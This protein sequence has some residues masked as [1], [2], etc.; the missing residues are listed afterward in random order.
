MTAAAFHA[1]AE[2]RLAEGDPAGARVLLED[3]LRL[4]PRCLPAALALAALRLPEDPAAA[5]AMAEA[6]RRDHPQD[7]RVLDLLGQ[8]VSALGRTAHAVAAFAAACAAAPRDAGRA[9]NLAVAELRAGDA[10]ASLRTAQR[11]AALDPRLPEA[12]AAIGHALAAL[13]RHEEALEAFHASLAL[14]PAQA[15][16]LLGVARS[17]RALGEAE[18][19]AIALLRAHEVAPEAIEPAVELPGALAEAA[20]AEAARDAAALLL[21]HWPA[22]LAWH[23]NALLQAQYDPAVPEEHA[24]ALAAEWGR[25]MMAAVAPV[26]RAAPAGAGRLRIGYVSADLRRHPVG[27]LGAA[28]IAAHD[29]AR[30]EVTVYDGQAGGDDLTARLRAAVEHW[31]PVAG[32]D[33]ATLA[34]RIAADGIEVLVDLAGHTAGN[35]LGVFA[36]RA[37]P[38]QVAWLGYVGTTGLPAMDAVLMDADHAPPGSG[39]LFTERL[40]RL[41]RIRFAY[42]PPP[43][44]PAVAPPPCLASGQVTFGCFNNLAKLNAAVVALW[45]ALLAR[46]PGSRLLLKWRSLADPAVQARLRAGFAAHGIAP[47]RIACEG[48]EPH[49]A[50]LAR[51]GAVDIALDPFPFS[52]G[53]TSA[54]ALWMGVPVVTLPGR[55]AASRQTHAMLRAIGHEAWSAPSPAAFLDIAAALAAD[56]RHL[57]Q[58]RAG[59]RAAVREGPLGDPAGLAAALEAAYRALAPRRPEDADAL[60]RE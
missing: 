33:D 2:R 21:R 1:A 29:R 6:M 51:Y 47:D 36:R 53:L 14:R 26:P 55:R 15:D 17:C 23:G 49:A 54:E 31:V 32:L 43:E 35:R 41:P 30:V 39:R 7:P 5:A 13:H 45:S 16:A 19:G 11:A 59:L 50:L 60:P 3:A 46:V 42:E 22:A 8:A 56:P 20:D 4:D 44:A 37:A 58:A 40:L 10:A 52:G 9:S 34:R 24:T 48:A 28:A 18:S 38:V 27:W 25:R 12:R 57:V